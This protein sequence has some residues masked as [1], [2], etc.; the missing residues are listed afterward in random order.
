MGEVAVNRVVVRE[1]KEEEEEEE[2]E[3][4]YKEFKRKEREK[5]QT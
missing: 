3:E 2:E 1:K 5:N 4:V